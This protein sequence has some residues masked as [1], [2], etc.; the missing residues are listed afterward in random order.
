MRLLILVIFFIG[1]N[2]MTLARAES[3]V[4]TINWAELNQQQAQISARRSPY[5][6]LLTEGIGKTT[7]PVYLPASHAYDNNMSVVADKN[8]YTIT[9]FLNGATL[10]ISGDKSY[11]QSMTQDTQAQ[12]IQQATQ[13]QRF[14]RA[15][16]M[17]TT[18][19]NR[20][21]ANYSL[22]LECNKPDEDQRC[23]ED[24]FLKQRYQELILV[25]GHP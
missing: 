18:D 9:F 10:I 7:L 20:Y 22:L 19:F 2:M 1:S 16:G 11:Q 4:L 25:G 21:G 17:M 5:P 12:A 15:E 3:G 8:F 24:N 6:S 23:L 13:T 14:V